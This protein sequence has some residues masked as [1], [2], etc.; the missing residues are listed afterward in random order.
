[1]RSALLVALPLVLLPLGQGPAEAA[2]G[3]VVLVS[4]DS[5][6]TE[7]DGASHASRMGSGGRYV[8]F[9]SQATNLDAAATSGVYQIF[10][11]DTVTGNVVLASG[12]VAGV[13]ADSECHHPFMTPDG[14]YVVFQSSANNLTGAGT[15]QQIYRKDLGS[16]TPTRT[17]AS[18]STARAC[19][20]RGLHGEGRARRSQTTQRRTVEK[21]VSHRRSR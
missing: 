21:Q 3:D 16:V 8:A 9:Q 17:V 18:L 7:G 15:I 10:R 1:M 2:G 6:W 11:K 4:S 14:R 12:N 5:S 19:S 20:I 13:E